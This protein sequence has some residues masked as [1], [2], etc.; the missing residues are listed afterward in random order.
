MTPRLSDAN[1]LGLDY[2]AEA[3]SFPYTG[4]IIDLHTHVSSPEAAAVFLDAAERFGVV[5]TWTMTGLEKARRVRGFAGDKIEFICVPDYA[6]RDEPGTFTTQW[7]KDIEA[8]RTELGSR[9]IKFWAAPR[10]LDVAAGPDSP[11]RLDSPIRLEGMK[12][13]YDLGYRIF[14]THVGDPDTW[15]AT[16]YADAAKY[17]T[18]PDQFI[19]L[20]RLMD[21]YDD[22]TWIGAH[23]SGSPENLDFVQGLLD[24]HP[25][26]LVDTSATKWMVRELSKHPQRFA[27]FC[28]ANP[29][30]VLFGTDIVANDE[31][32]TRQDDDD[33]H[34]PDGYDLY[35]S[36]FWA[37]RT[38]LETDYDG[39]S[40]IV[41]PDLRLIDPSA[42]P[43]STATLRGCGMRGN[44]LDDIYY[45]N[46]ANLM[47]L[48]E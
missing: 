3:A 19:A 17:G 38:L 11:L 9:I 48:V 39:P 44:L 7:L 47:G 28:E 5:K 27:T 22:V 41:D 4:P 21:Q 24:R 46:A 33:P 36:R 34:K 12:L 14:M 43:K 6:K 23:L 31:N 45:R 8:F 30:R 1:R 40:P 25:N 2:A 13:A 29:G 26:Y 18:K 37:L 15:F 16:T 42:D 20:E 10:G 32:V 35:A